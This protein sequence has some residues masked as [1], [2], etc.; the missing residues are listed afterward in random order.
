MAL[1][2]ITDVG[3]TINAFAIETIS[4]GMFVKGSANDDSVT[5]SGVASYA[6]DEIKVAKMDAAAD[7][8][9]VVG[10]AMED[11]LSGEALTVVTEGLY[12]LPAQDAIT[13]GNSISPSNDDDAFANSVTVTGD[14]EE[15]FKIGRALTSASAS[16]TFIIAHLRI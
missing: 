7:D 14:G 11:A 6:G 16:G 3:R 1:A 12:V 15:E 4:A 9:F 2:Q 8:E 5:S 13:A 10:I